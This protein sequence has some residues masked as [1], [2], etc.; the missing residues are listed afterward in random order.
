MF[1]IRPHER[2]VP[3]PVT[4]SPKLLPLTSRSLSLKPAHCVSQSLRRTKSN[5][6]NVNAKKSIL[7]VFSLCMKRCFFLF[8]YLTTH[9]NL[10][11]LHFYHIVF[12]SIPPSYTHQAFTR[13]QLDHVTHEYPCIL[14]VDKQ[15]WVFQ[16]LISL[17]QFSTF[18]SPLYLIK[19]R[20]QGTF[21]TRIH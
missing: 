9:E 18:F 10:F 14:W 21:L 13:K 11:S 16:A 12:L 3:C 1:C 5:S 6:C 19:W 2:T 15:R 17:D 8:A 4:G 20:I 7:L